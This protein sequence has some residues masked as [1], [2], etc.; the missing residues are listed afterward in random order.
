MAMHVMRRSDRIAEAKLIEK[1]QIKKARRSDTSDFELVARK[2]VE[3]VMKVR[4]AM[5]ATDTKEDYSKFFGGYEQCDLLLQDPAYRNSADAQFAY[6]LLL[7]ADQWL[8][9][10]ADKLGEKYIPP[11]HFYKA[12]DYF[13]IDLR[14]KSV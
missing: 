9:H 8:K 7:G 4:E 6:Q 3:A 1:A 12:W 11:E 10:E 13:G 14:G 5:A 2:F